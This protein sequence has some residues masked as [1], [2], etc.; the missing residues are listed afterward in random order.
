DYGTDPLDAD[1]DDDGVIDGNEVDDYGTDPLDTDTDDDGIQD[2]TELGRSNGHPTDTDPAVFI[3][4]AD[5]TTTTDPLDADTDDGGISD[6]VEDA[7]ANGAIDAGE[8]DP[9]DPVDDTFFVD[10]DGDGLSDGAETVGSDGIPNSGDE[11]D[12]FDADTDDDGLTDGEEVLD[13][14]TDPNN[15]DTDADGLFDG[16]EAGVTA[17]DV[18][19]DTDTS[20]FMP[21]ADPTT[22]T[23]PND[24]DSD[25]DGLLDGT[26]DGSLDGTVD[27]GETDPNAMDSDGDGLQDGTE[28]GLTA[29]EGADTDPTVFVPDADATTHTDPLDDDSDDDGLLDGTEDANGDGAWTGTIGNSG[30]PGAGETQPT[31]PDTD[32]DGIQDGTE[33]GLDTP[34]GS[35]T[36]SSVFQP[37]ADPSTTTDPSDTDTDDGGVDDGAEDDNADGAIDPGETDPL[38]AAD[39]ILDTDGDGLLDSVEDANGNG[40]L[41]PGE[42]DPFDADTDDDG[43]NDGDEVN[44]TGPLAPWAPTD[45][46]NP[47]T[48]DDGI[49][50]GTE[51]GQTLDDIGPDTDTDGF[52]PDSDPSTTT[53]PNS[54][55]TDSDGL[56]DGDE[57]ADGNGAIDPG[58]TDPNN[59]DTDG[60]GFDDGFE[61]DN[62]LDPVAPFRGQGSGCSTTGL[63]GAGG[64]M[65]LALAALGVA[66]RR[67]TLAGAALAATTSTTAAAQ[68]TPPQLDVQRFDPTPQAATWTLVRDANQTRKGEFTAMLSSNYAYRPFELAS[69]SNGDRIAG[70]I[71]HMVGFDLAATY[72]A[73]DWFEVGLSIPVTQLTFGNDPLLVALGGTGANAGIGDMALSLGFAP[74]RQG[75]NSAVDVSVVPRFVFPT[76]TR[77]TFVGSGAA[78]LGLDAAVGRRWKHLRVGG[79]LGY[80]LQTSSSEVAGI[81]ADDELRWGLGL[82]VP[83]RSSTW[84]VG[85]EFAGATV[86]GGQ[87]RNVIGELYSAMVH[88]PMELVFAVMHH[89]A[90][91]P[92]W[93]RFG[94]GPGLSSG[95]GTPDVRAF[96]QFGYAKL[97]TSLLDS[98]RDGFTDAD[99]ACPLE[100]EDR[101]GFNDADGCPDLDNDNDGVP[102]VRDGTLAEG[103]AFGDCMNIPEDRDGFEDED[104]CP[105]TDNDN[106]GIADADDAC[107]DAAEDTDGFEDDN[108]CPDSDNDGDGIVD[109]EDGHRKEDGSITWAADV[110]GFG[111]CMNAAEVINGVD[112][113][114]GCPDEARIVVNTESKQIEI[115]ETVFFKLNRASIEA[116]SYPLLEE[117]AALL[118]AYPNLTKVEVAGHTDSR[119]S[120]TANQRLS[121]KRVESVQAFLVARGVAPERLVAKGYGESQP[122]VADAKTEAQHAENR[123]VEFHILEQADDAPEVESREDGVR[124]IEG[125][126]ANP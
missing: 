53:D 69:A 115:L 2:G 95:W 7:N 125:A 105:D 29:P 89:S 77:G 44:G 121:Q 52:V 41:D 123:R 36:D 98:D 64:L 116:R 71:D 43:I 84:E 78:G 86:V 114:D 74:L 126:E 19:P 109:T 54:A 67:R 117:V 100:A 9:N 91:T 104:G 65:W 30:T 75:D 21:D 50:D 34:E 62:L 45:P 81:Y 49:D 16:T 33:L 72:A 28:S 59:P 32:G 122:K 102:D 103:S 40:I 61:Q 26:E 113:D 110:E 24:D 46:L 31:N 107:P 10:S 63:P 80:Q 42:T 87:G 47:D 111:D 15:A 58:E 76:G 22:T 79:S 66:R 119:G 97:D 118:L 57:D 60:D 56:H 101:D 11:T 94:G 37:D 48:D 23:D 51:T 85:A 106:D 73:T 112:D 99:D 4:D 35:G 70:V 120:A 5:P 14:G 92:V 20:V 8:I 12:P 38:E 25:D 88:T 82:A 3:P 13:M 17:D 68:E 83:F 55:D 93:V 39:D 6:G 1:S 96:V 18:G 108:G 27:A 124:Y 90:K